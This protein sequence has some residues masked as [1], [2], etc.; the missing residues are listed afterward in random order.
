MKSTGI[1]VL[2]LLLF[3]PLAYSW[4]AETHEKLVENVYLNMDGM[5]WANLSL[6]K[7]GAVAPDAVFRDFHLH[8]Y[9]ES[10]YQAQ[11]WLNKSKDALAKGDTELASYAFGAASHYISDSFV[12]P[13]YIKGEEPYL[14]AR[15]ENSAKMGV[16]CSISEFPAINITEKHQDWQDFLKGNNNVQ[17]KELGQAQQAVYYTA[18]ILFNAVCKEKNNN[19]GVWKLFGTAVILGLACL[20]WLRRKKPNQSQCQ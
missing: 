20:I 4:N 12:A 17:S 18:H 14:H 10:F 5:D 7:L 6:M 16:S 9:P 13:H 2:I 19:L 11:K 3:V 8:H 1:I 15:F